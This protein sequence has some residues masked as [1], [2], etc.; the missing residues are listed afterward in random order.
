DLDREG[1]LIE[2]FDYLATFEEQYNFEYYPRLIEKCGYS[3]EVDWF[4]Y[5]LF[6]PKEMDARVQRLSFSVLKRYNLKI[7]KEK[8]KKK[9][10]NKYKEGIFNIIDEAYGPLYGTIPFTDELRNQ[11]I[12]QFES[13]L[14][15]KYIVTILDEN[16]KV[17]AFGFVIPSLSDAIRKSKGRIFPF[18]IF[19]L[20]RA[21]K[22]G[23]RADFG[24][25]GVNQKYLNK[26]LPAV[27]INEI[28]KTMIE[29][30]LEYCETNLM[31]EDNVK[32]QN[33]WDNYD[34][35]QHKRRRCYIKGLDKKIAIKKTKTDDKKGSSTK[36]KVINKTENKTSGK[37]STK[38]ANKSGSKSTKTFDKNEKVKAIKSAKPTKK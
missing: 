2:G 17:I 31:L 7:A 15:L 1:L 11:I 14:K 19:R 27:V 28:M 9:Y 12:C 8:S 18:G 38:T 3:K 30:K 13:F 37:A 5:R 36:D 26:G 16:D 22:F 34:H 6:P 33:I 32:I 20:L 25:I 10:I 21:I 35:I 23:K 24:L 4:E 29:E